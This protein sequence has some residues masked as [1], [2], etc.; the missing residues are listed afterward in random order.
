MFYNKPGQYFGELALL[1]NECRAATIRSVTECRCLCLH[2]DAFVALL[3]PLQDIM[4]AKSKRDYL[5]YQ[6]GIGIGVCI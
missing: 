2:R 4:N 3:G 6:V 1:H 5:Q